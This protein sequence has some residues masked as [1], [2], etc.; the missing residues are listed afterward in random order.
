MEAIN[1][2]SNTIKQHLCRDPFKMEDQVGFQKTLLEHKIVKD[3]QLVNHHA[4]ES[5]L[6]V[7]RSVDLQGQ[8]SSNWWDA[9]GVAS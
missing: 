2:Q 3:S 7:Q 5:L 8:C 6:G 9:M 4:H 1:G